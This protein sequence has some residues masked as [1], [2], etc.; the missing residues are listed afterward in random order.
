MRYILLD[1]ENCTSETTSLST[2]HLIHEHEQDISIDSAKK[3]DF[4][5][6]LVALTNRYSVIACNTH[7]DT[8][9]H[10]CTH[11]HTYIHSHSHAH[12]HTLT[13][14]SPQ[15]GNILSTW[16]DRQTIVH[17]SADRTM[18]FTTSPHCSGDVQT[19]LILMPILVTP[20]HCEHVEVALC[21]FGNR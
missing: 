1:D 10:A 3:K 12:K 17:S 4:V 21:M 2:L 11:V 6:A 8:H 19:I 9:T 5:T 13:H 14:T 15:A 18:I 20:L 16:A 7:T